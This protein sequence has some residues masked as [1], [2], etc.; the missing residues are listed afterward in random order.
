MSVT[1]YP[2]RLFQRVIFLGLDGLYHEAKV[3][4]VTDAN[5]CFARIIPT[6]THRHLQRDTTEAWRGTRYFLEITP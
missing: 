4:T 2:L 1:E 5:N 3:T 6:E